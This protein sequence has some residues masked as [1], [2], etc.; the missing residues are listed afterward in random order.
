MATD[1]P[2]AGSFARKQQAARA[3]QALRESGFADAQL[4]YLAPGE[5]PASVEHRPADLS[6]GEGAAEGAAIGA[7]T[8]VVVGSAPGLAAI[9]GLVP[10]FGPAL[11]GGALVAL[12]VGGGATAMGGLVGYLMGQGLSDE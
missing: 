2:L 5:G 9:A 11:A 3:I 8:G 12:I 6:S 4:G 1:R 10:P 7:T